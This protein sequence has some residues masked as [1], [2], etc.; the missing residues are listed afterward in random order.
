MLKQVKVFCAAACIGAAAGCSD[1][2]APPTPKVSAGE[3]IFIQNC[4]VCH[5]Q[6]INGAPIIGNITMWQK[7]VGQGITTLVQ[8]AMNGHG[9][10]P[11]KG[12]KPELT[13]A[14]IELAVRYMVSR[15]DPAAAAQ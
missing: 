14:E 15:V 7:R 1:D 9:L 4:N 13:E 10:M 2:A 8:H 11:A 6:G 12:G 3:Q 5:A